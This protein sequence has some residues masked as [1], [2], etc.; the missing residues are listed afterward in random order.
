MPKNSK[1][2]SKKRSKDNNKN[3]ELIFAEDLQTY[4]RVDK[5]L[6]DGRFHLYCFDINDY[7]IGQIRGSIKKYTWIKKD[8]IV[9]I[10]LRDFDE[11]KCD[12]IHKYLDDEI[13]SLQKYKE[14]PE[15]YQLIEEHLIDSY[16][17][18]SFCF[19]IDGI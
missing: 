14:I 18:S 1:K 2:G 8:N 19:D 6:G 4:A 12:I 3:R 5:E 15:K 10:S 7:R 9:L 11:Q 13:K 17:D 16:N